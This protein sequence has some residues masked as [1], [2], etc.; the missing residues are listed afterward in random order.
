MNSKRFVISIIAIIFF[1]I[2]VIYAALWVLPE[3]EYMQGEYSAWKQQKE[4]SLQQHPREV[5]LLGDSRMKI[6]VNSV[7]L[8][9]TYNLALAGSSPIEAHYTLKR[10]LAAGNMPSAV[11]I[12]FAPTHLASYENYLDRGLFFHYYDENEIKEINAN[13]LL[14]EGVDYNMESYKYKW[15]SPA[16]YLTTLLHS[17]KE[18]RTSINANI[19]R[20]MIDCKGTLTLDG[21]RSSDKPVK[22]EETKEKSFK[23]KKVLDY[24]LRETISLCKN[25]N[26]PVY[27]VQLPMGAYGVEILQSTGY[28]Q[29]YED[30]MELLADD[31]GIY[32]ERQIPIFPDEMFA[33]D[34]HLNKQG[35]C[36]YTKYIKTLYDRNGE[37]R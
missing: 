31:Y 16:V 8:A 15:R 7:E 34:S 18:D 23:L 29:Q 4:Y 17:L 36:E 5:I 35:Q 9:N 1:L 11:Y 3:E 25:Y 30:Y 14:Y 27:I 19:Y 26:I 22:P 32:V 37:I 33:D 10:Y 13:I 28:L 21:V 2:G 6:D 12:G 24:Y 20:E